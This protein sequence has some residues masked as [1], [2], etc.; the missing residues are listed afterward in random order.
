MNRIAA[1][2]LFALTTLAPI[3]SASA[4]QLTGPTNIPFAFT[5]NGK[6]LPAGTYMIGSIA[7]SSPVLEIRSTSRPISVFFA[8]HKDQNNQAGATTL[9]FVKCGDQY[10]LHEI[11]SLVGDTDAVVP[12]S[13][14]EKK[15]RIEMAKANAGRPVLVAINQGER[16]SR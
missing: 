9:V 3:A 5:V 14:I 16:L 10:L 13:Q 11:F 2:A 12:A 6:T 4:Q 1:V 8:T 7:V 15:A